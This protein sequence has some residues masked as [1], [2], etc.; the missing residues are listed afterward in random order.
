MNSMNAFTATNYSTYNS[1]VAYLYQGVGFNYYDNSPKLVK[2]TAFG[3]YK[4]LSDSPLTIQY[5]INDGVKWTDGTPVDAADMILAWGSSITK[6]NDT[7]GVNFGSINAGSG[8]DYVTKVPKISNNN[9]T[10]TITYDKPYVD[11]EILPAITPNLSAAVVW[12]EAGIDKK[13]GTDAQNA[14]VKACQGVEDRLRHDQHP[15]GRQAPDDLRPLQGAVADQAV[16][17]DGRQPRL[18]VGPEAEDRQGHGALHPR[19][20]RTGPGPQERRAERAL[21]PGHG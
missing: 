6:Y 5:T 1:N 18:H 19:P 15:E 12:E 11:W 7:K 9:H 14:V 16:H 17:H 4:K 3:T 13:T 2:N 8:L 20:D 21:R 10:I